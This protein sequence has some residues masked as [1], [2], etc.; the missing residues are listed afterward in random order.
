MA[1]VLVRQSGLTHPTDVAKPLQLSI[2]G[3]FAN[4]RL[5]LMSRMNHIAGDAIAQGNS[6][7][8]AQACHLEDV[9]LVEFLLERSVTGRQNA[10]KAKCYL[11]SSSYMNAE[12][13][14]IV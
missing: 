10:H 7:N 8:L 9:E 2:L 1:E 11:P 4:S 13:P 14:T 5:L 12:M 6:K 3:H